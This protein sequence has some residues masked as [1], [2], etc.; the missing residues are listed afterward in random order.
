[1]FTLIVE[2]SLFLFSSKISLYFLK[3][4]FNKKQ[5]CELFKLFELITNVIDLY[6]FISFSTKDSSFLRETLCLYD[7]NEKKRSQKNL[8]NRPYLKRCLRVILNRHSLKSL[9][10][11][12]DPTKAHFRTC[13]FHSLRLNVLFDVFLNSSIFI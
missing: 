1:M 12:L 4:F 3:N 11:C 13:L 8:L 10:S 7:S 9:L 5:N 2:F 6:I